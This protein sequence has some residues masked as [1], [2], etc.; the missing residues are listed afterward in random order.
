[1]PMLQTRWTAE[2]ILERVRSKRAPSVGNQH[3]IKGY[4]KADY[5]SSFRMGSTDPSKPF[6]VMR[7]KHAT[8]A[9]PGV[10]SHDSFHSRIR[11]SDGHVSRSEANTE[12]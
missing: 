3:V 2:S 6:Q 10:V 8:Y 1:M 5:H 12:E 4:E 11:A 9:L 7:R